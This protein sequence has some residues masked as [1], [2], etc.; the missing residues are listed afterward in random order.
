MI[1]DKNVVDWKYLRIFSM[2]NCA[3]QLIVLCEKKEKAT[4]QTEKTKTKPKKGWQ[5]TD[6]FA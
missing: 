2:A 3:P 6:G 4:E 1:Y 5:L